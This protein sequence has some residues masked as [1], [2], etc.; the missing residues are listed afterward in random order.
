MDKSELAAER[1]STPQEL[2]SQEARVQQGQ[3]GHLRVD[4]GGGGGHAAP[5]TASKCHRPPKKISA[6][7][8]EGLRR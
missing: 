3:D 1:C 2:A 5:A 4:K 6:E 7:C 8:S